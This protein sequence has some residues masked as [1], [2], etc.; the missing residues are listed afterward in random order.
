MPAASDSIPID[1]DNTFARLP[2]SFYTRQNPEPVSAPQLVCLNERLAQS[3]GIDPAWLRSNSGVS[4]LAG[5]QVLTGSEP[6]AMVYAGHQFG[7]WVPRLGDGRALLLGEVVDTRQRRYDIQ[8]KGAGRTPYSRGGDGRAWLGPAIR[9]YLVSE[10]MHAMGVSSTRALA[11]V[12]TGDAVYR[13]SVLP[14]AIVVRVAGSHIRVGTFQYFYSQ[15]DID[16]LRRLTNYV[17]ERH[18]PEVPRAE[19]NEALT[20][21]TQVVGRQAALVARWQALGFIHGVMNT[22]NCSVNGETIDYGPCAFMDDY[23]AGKV[24]SSIDTGGRYAYQNQPGIAHWNLAQLAQALLPLVDQQPE[25]A[26]A[27]AQQVIDQFPALYRQAWQAAMLAKLGFGAGQQ[28]DPARVDLV[29]TL[30]SLMESHGADFTQT[31]SALRETLHDRPLPVATTP[32]TL[33]MLGSEAFR[34]WQQQWL[35]QHRTAQDGAS[36]IPATALARISQA[37][38]VCIPR[39]HRIEQ[40]IVDCREENHDTLQRMFRAVTDPYAH[41]E[42]QL[43][44]AEAPIEREVVHQTFCGT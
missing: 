33:D 42:D 25:R 3:L 27:A 24:F 35:G 26:A 1:F 43:F 30:L 31:F 6:L 19:Q 37:N 5:N 29:D 10:A 34:S 44:H 39:N 38:P 18:Y 17:L 36:L 4:A 11:V 32:A 14:G 20:L 2:A 23:Q 16:S 7:N 21:L 40:V 22:D 41:G 28:R 13:E 15:Q 8:L 12:L 9:E